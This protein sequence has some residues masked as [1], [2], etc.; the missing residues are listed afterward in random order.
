MS[1]S[2]I[3][4]KKIDVENWIRLQYYFLLQTRKKTVILITI[5]YP[6]CTEW[7]IVDVK[8]I[9]TVWLIDYS[10]GVWNN[11]VKNWNLMDIIFL[12]VAEV[13]ISGWFNRWNLNDDAN[14]RRIPWGRWKKNTSI[15]E[16]HCQFF[17][18]DITEVSITINEL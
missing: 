12:I 18:L 15:S 3:K 17:C 7:L 13:G 16:L 1:I 9:L 11:I 8:K 4:Q 10:L 14:T 2:G 6:I 5:E